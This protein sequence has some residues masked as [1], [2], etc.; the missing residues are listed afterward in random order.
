MLW[1]GR[2]ES[3][4]VEDRR[5]IGGGGLA[6]GGGLGGIVLLV[7]ALLFGVDPRQLMEQQPT[8]DPSTGTQTSRSANPQEE[9]L[10]RF[11]TVV[12]AETEDVWNDIFRQNGRQYREPTLVLF[13]EQVRSACGNASAAVGPFYCPGDQK[14]YIDLSFFRELHSQFRAPGDFAQAY[15]IAHEIGHHVQHLLGTSD[16]VSAMQAR[17]GGAQANQLS[18]RLELQADFYAGVWAHYA[19]KRGIIE[20]GDFEEAMRAASAIGDDRLQREAQ[21]YVVPD[22]FTHG[23]SEQ[24]ARWFRRGLETGDIRQGDTFSARN[25]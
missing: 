4:N 9:E 5:G 3:G 1:K 21:G 11:T 25:P 20:P 6:I 15:V 18:V 13:T 23:T 12:L 16:R 22:S 10:K 17:A 7:V 2:R 24:R 14:V 19:Q 8:G